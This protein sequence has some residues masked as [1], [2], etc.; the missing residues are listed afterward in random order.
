[1]WSDYSYLVRCKD[2]QF[3]PNFFSHDRGCDNYSG[4]YVG[5]KNL[6]LYVSMSV[7]LK[8]CRISDVSFLGKIEVQYEASIVPATY[9]Y[10]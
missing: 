9:L 8:F 7:Y 5:C 10:A 1:M 2:A 4:Q 3:A 6:N